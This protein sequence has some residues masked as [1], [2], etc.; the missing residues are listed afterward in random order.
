MN[1]AVLQ[2]IRT[3][4]VERALT[5]AAVDAEQ[6][7]VLLDAVQ[8]A[9]HAGNRR[10]HHYVAVTEPDLL[11][12][13]RMVS[14]GMIQHPTAAIVICVD[15]GRLRGYGFPPSNHGPYVDVGTAAATLLLAAH[16]AGLAAGP[17]TSISRAAVATIL[18][19]PADV[20]PEMIVC[21]GHA[22]ATKHS[23]VRRHGGPRWADMVH[24]N[25]ASEAGSQG[26]G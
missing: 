12:A 14:P 6:L 11:R 16:A 20:R 13:V 7:E 9:P 24:W 21:L 8:Y 4:R 1:D 26:R 15:W 3:R 18:D 19:L 23:G 10:V 17:V 25:R 5:G 22:A 2:A